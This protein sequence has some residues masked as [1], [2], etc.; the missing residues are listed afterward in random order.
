[1]DEILAGRHLDQFVVDVFQA[2]AGPSPNMNE[3]AGLANRAN[4]TLNVGARRHSA[5][6]NP[7]DHVNMAQSTNDVTPT[8]IRLAL[9]DLTGPVIHEL[10]QLG[11]AFAPKS[12]EYAPTVKPGRTHLQDA[13]PITFG[14]EFG[15]WATRMRS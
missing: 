11:Q 2:G 14:Q 5:K 1:C 15:G 10:E 13:V 8:A 4:D 6:V 7:N 9:L 3:T 12:K